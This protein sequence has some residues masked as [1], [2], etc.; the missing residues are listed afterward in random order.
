MRSSLGELFGSSASDDGST[1][2]RLLRDIRS[3]FDSRT[4]PDA[5]RISSAEMVKTLH[6]I[7]GQPWADWNRGRG[8]TVNNLAS[9][10]KEYG[11]NPKTVRFSSGPLRG[12]RRTCLRTHGIVTVQLRGL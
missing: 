9:K 10:L 2:V 7:E 12:T 6:E 4:E 8:L 3:I 1:G 5:D 11:I